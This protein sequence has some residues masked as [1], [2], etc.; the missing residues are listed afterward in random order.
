MSSPEALR[1]VALDEEDLAVLSA[2]AQDAILKIGDLAWRP[3]ERRFALAMNRFAW[4]TAADGERLPSYT[5]RRAI[6]HFDRITAVKTAKLDRSLPETPLELLAIAFEPGDSPAGSITLYFAGG[7]VIRLEAECI[8][9]R[10]TDL[11]AEW[12]TRVKPVHD[13]ADG[14]DAIRRA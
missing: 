3:R 4:E 7:G 14:D 10:L 1:L 9:A 13:L 11:G 6:L 5:R 2:H 12:A 8:E